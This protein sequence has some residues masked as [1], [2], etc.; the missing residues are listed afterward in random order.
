MKPFKFFIYYQVEELHL[1]Q[2]SLD[3]FN[4]NA[5]DNDCA[6]DNI[7]HASTPLLSKSIPHDDLSIDDTHLTFDDDDDE[8]VVQ[9]PS[10][11]RQ[12]QSALK[13]NL[14]AVKD[15]EGASKQE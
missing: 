10:P 5:A 8:D 3:G 6:V 14:N 7:V 1:N 2:S 15:H 9:G 4:L 11:L 13:E 12:I